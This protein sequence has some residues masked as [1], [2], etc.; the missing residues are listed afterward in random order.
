MYL[1]KAN[2]SLSNSNNSKNSFTLIEVLVAIAILS[3]VVVIFYSTWWLGMKTIRRSNEIAQKY[4]GAR[5]FMDNLAKELRSAFEFNYRDYQDFVWDANAKR[6]EFWGVAPDEVPVIYTYP[7]PIHRYIYYIK[8]EN[9]HNVIYKRVEPLYVNY[10]EKYEA[11]EGPILE[12]DF[13]LEINPIYPPGKITTPLP[14]RVIVT[15]IIEGKY[16]LEKVIYINGL[17]KL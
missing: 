13:D 10:P 5:V 8:K 9:A 12:G 4:M 7:F 11:V 14:E 2:C 1:F 15:L 6:L 17:K 16:R 3:I